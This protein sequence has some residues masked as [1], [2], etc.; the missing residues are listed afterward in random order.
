MGTIFWII[1][2]IAG[3]LAEA[4]TFTLISIWFAVGAL[5]ALIAAICGAGTALQIGIFL[6]VS[7]ISLAA[8]RPVLKKLMPN[9][10]IPTN[11]ELD[12]GRNAIVIEKID[13][14]AGTGRVRLDGVDW[15]AASADGSVINEGESVVV[16]DKGAAYLTV[17]KAE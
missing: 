15:G 11:G 10:Y 17:V 9:G 1:I 8:T 5:A 16:R 2:L 12:I 7:I 4:A 6:M 13:P 14:K 3:I